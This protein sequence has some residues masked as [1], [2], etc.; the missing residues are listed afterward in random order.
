MKPLRSQDFGA[1]LGNPA[2][3]AKTPRVFRGEGA[4]MTSAA[5]RGMRG[6]ME[7]HAVARSDPAAPAYQF[8][9]SGRSSTL[10]DHA[11]RSWWAMWNASSAIAEG[12]QKNSSGLSAATT[13]RVRGVSMAASTRM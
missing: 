8:S 3:R 4:A 2:G 13:G 10:N 5:A 11:E 1:R 6:A 12:L 9:M 7:D